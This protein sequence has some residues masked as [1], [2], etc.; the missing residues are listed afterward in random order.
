MNFVS[1]LTKEFGE[2]HNLFFETNHRSGKTLKI[3]TELCR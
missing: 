1:K 3:S 2:K